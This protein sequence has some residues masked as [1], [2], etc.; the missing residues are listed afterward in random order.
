MKHVDKLDR[1]ECK[2]EVEERFSSKAMAEKYEKFYY[3]LIQGL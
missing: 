3:Q 1:R 2:R